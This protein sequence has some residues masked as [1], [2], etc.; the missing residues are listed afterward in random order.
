MIDTDNTNRERERLHWVKLDA[1]RR[2]RREEAERSLKKQQ[3]TI[4]IEPTEPEPTL[5]G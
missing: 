4:A 1:K 2:K 5:A 3:E